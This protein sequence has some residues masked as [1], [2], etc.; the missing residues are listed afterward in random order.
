M[1]DIL[2]SRSLNNH[3]IRIESE[4]M[5][6]IL[7][8]SEIIRYRKPTY[9]Y[10]VLFPYYISNGKSIPYTEKELKT[11]FPKA[12]EYLLENKT[13]LLKRSK[14]T[15]DNWWLYPYPKNLSLFNKPKI[16]S[17]VLSSRGSFVL[18]IEGEFH[19][20]GGG[21]AGGNGIICYEDNADD[22][23]FLLGILNSSF[24]FSHVRRVGS[25]F[26]GGFFSFSKASLASLPIPIICNLESQKI[27]TAIINYVEKMGEINLK[28]PNTPQEKDFLK[29]ELDI[30]ERQ[31]DKLVYELYG[32]T[33]EEIKI[34]E[35][36]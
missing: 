24:C 9:K 5:H 29:R 6:P 15:Q 8:G 13:A 26:R 17:Q 27:K 20:L 30:T 28:T 10:K 35:G 33:E 19:F 22:L 25:S 2:V 4:L 1:D 7:K 12:Y 3:E 34:V 18:D 23:K 16:I 31:I 21:N 36:G 32:L 11:N 14:T